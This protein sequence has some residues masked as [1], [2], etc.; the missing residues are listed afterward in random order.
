MLLN[1]DDRRVMWWLA[2]AGGAGLA[3]WYLSPILMPFVL[4]GVLAYIWQP[5]VLWLDRRRL[6]RTLSVLVV[7]FLEAVLLLLF[8]LTVLPL[9]VKEIMD[10]S[11]QL[12]GLLDKANETLAPW[13]RSRLGIDVRLDPASVR[14]TI[15][16]AIANTE[17]LGMRVLESLRMGGLGLLGLFANLVLAPVVQFFLMRDWESI[18]SRLAGLIPRAWTGRV[19][20]FVREADEALSQYLHGQVMVI[21]VMVVF[22]AAGL[23]ITG[24]NFW[25]PV[26]LI[27]GLM[28]FVPYVGAA[29][30]FVLGSLAALLQFQDWPGLVWVWV[31]F[32]L[33]QALEGNLVTPKLVGDRIGLHPLAVIFALLAFGQLFSFTGLLVALPVSAVL[34]VALRELRDRYLSS[35]LYKGE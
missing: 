21:A 18:Q 33:G 20:G 26:G 9:F 17:G 6:P 14:E 3:L 8:L 12:P 30:G 15:S 16:A 35:S 13:I 23:W 32:G 11:R 10:L 24:L 25:L 19:Q 2:I 1:P 28:V 31:V 22:Y 4:G 34:L 27:T 29:V 7:I 5:L